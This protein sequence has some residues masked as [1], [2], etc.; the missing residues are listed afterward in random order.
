MYIGYAAAY[1]GDALILMGAADDD[2]LIL[3]GALLVSFMAP[4]I[5]ST[6]VG[7]AGRNIQAAADSFPPYQYGLKEA[8]R[9]F[10]T[11]RDRMHSAFVYF[12]LG[13]GTFAVGRLVPDMTTS[14]DIAT[15]ASISIGSRTRTC[16]AMNGCRPR[17]PTPQRPPRRRVRWPPRKRPA[18]PPSFSWLRTSWRARSSNGERLPGEV[19]C[20]H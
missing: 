6:Y 17:R 19:P 11:Y 7:T 5:A 18:K 20:R 2:P 9:N 4:L 3:T 13:L 14:M 12:G 10:E 8:G 15:L 1:A 16:G